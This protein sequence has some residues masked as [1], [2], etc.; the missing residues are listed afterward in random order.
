MLINRTEQNSVVDALYESSNIISSRYNKTTSE[1]RL[2]FKSGI[3]YVYENVT[4]SDYHK[5]ELSDSQGRAFN[6]Y[7]RSYKFI[8]GDKVNIQEVFERIEVV[9]QEEID[10]LTRHIA[11]L[12]T[13][14][15][16]NYAENGV[17]TESNMGDIVR[18][19][20]TR[21]TKLKK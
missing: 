15:S 9:K 11:E 10:D 18:M 6:K 20:E 7:L 3:E 14:M 5:L 2:I 21:N 17:I 12:A 8:K 19:I 13:L 16:N 4:L 1:L